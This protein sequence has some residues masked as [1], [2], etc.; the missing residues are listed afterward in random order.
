MSESTIWFVALSSTLAAVMGIAT[1]FIQKWISLVDETL[2][3]HNTV[4]YKVSS[5]VSSLQS[6]QSRS[7]ENIAETIR[8]EIGRNNR[9]PATGLSEIK[10]EIKVLKEVVQLRVLPHVDE[11]KVQLGKIILIE[12]NQDVQGKLITKLYETIKAVIEKSSRPK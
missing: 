10:H 9:A 6:M 3:E 1:F 5:Q 8:T 11:I 4:I 12:K 2:K 7:S